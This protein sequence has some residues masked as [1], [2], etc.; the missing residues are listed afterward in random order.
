MIV[1]KSSPLESSV[2]MFS[3][4]KNTST[5]FA[6]SSRSVTKVSTVFRAKRLMDFVTMRSIFPARA[7]EIISLNPSLFFTLVPLMPS[8][9]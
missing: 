9:E 8:S 7:S 3:F 4:S 1:T 6:L 5:P 2:W